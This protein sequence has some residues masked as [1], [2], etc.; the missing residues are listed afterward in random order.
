MDS[1]AIIVNRQYLPR[2]YVLIHVARRKGRKEAH[3]THYLCYPHVPRAQEIPVLAEQRYKP[4]FSFT[5]LSPNPKG[6]ENFGT[7]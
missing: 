6:K 5:E 2:F 3:E 1:D 4:M 7:P